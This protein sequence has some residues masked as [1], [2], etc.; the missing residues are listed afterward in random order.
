M[1]DVAVVAVGPGDEGSEAVC[2][3]LPDDGR[4]LL[5]SEDDVALAVREKGVEIR[6][7]SPALLVERV[8]RALGGP[9]A[10]PPRAASGAGILP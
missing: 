8:R 3:K 7:A 1:V 9:D 6:Q 10:P 5:L 4:T 2:T